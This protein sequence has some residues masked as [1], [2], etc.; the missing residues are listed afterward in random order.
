MRL[1]LFTTP[2]LYFCS[3]IACTDKVKP[4][5]IKA[6][7]GKDTRSAQIINLNVDIGDKGAQE[8]AE[9]LRDDVCLRGMYVHVG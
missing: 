4:P 8:F 1:H 7:T 6:Q 9:A 3:N 5:I 2:L